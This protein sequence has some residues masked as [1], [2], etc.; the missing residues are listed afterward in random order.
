MI[1]TDNKKAI[2]QVLESG[3]YHQ[4]LLICQQAIEFNPE[5]SDYYLYL[6]LAYLL[7]GQEVE[8]SEIWL[9]WLLESE[10]SQDLITLLKK[11]ITRNLDHGW[12]SQA[13]LIYL[14][15]LGLKEIDADEEIEIYAISAI[16]L[17]RQQV[18]D[19]I[20]Y[21]NYS[22]AESFYFEILHWHDQLA[23]IWQELG[24]LY[25][26]INRLGEAFNCLSKALDLDDTQASYHYTMGMILEKQLRSDLAIL[27][28]QTSIKLA[29]NFTDAYNKLG[30][31]YYQLGQLDSAEKSYQ[32]GINIK[33]NFYP[34]YLNLGNVYLVQQAW[35]KAAKADGVTTS[36]KDNSVGN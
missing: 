23:Y 8:A 25:Y 34:F 3:D 36:W 5:I 26:I 32:Q 12:F 20:N 27:A 31:L 16:N 11:E 17:C 14:Q 28:Y 15:L 2:E 4:L 30:N 13:K 22:L 24:Y 35:K 19:L 1:N 7:M 33:A 10:S 29:Y 9:S 18:Q 21:Q 6:G